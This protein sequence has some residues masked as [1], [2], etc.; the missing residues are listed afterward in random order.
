MLSRALSSSSPTLKA[1][2]LARTRDALVSSSS[3]THFVLPSGASFI[4]RPPPSPLPPSLPHP[5]PSPSPS[6]SSSFPFLTSSSSEH[7]LPPSHPHTPSPTTLSPSQISSLQSLRR[8][9]PSYWTRA[10]LAQKF[11]VGPS[12]VARFG[13]GDG[14]EG[15]D[16]ERSRRDHVQAEREASEARWGW[17]KAISREERRRRRALW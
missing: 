5:S 4:V 1:R 14:K 3:S 8:S 6:S 11:L 2:P 16:A 7:L 10:R 17:R 12:V 9:N 13:W 15:R